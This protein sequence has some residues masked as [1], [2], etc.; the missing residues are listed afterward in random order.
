MKKRWAKR[1]TTRREFM[2]RSVRAAG[3]GVAVPYVITGD[4]LA[5]PGRPGAND[6]IQ[7]GHIGINWMGGD[8]HKMTVRDPMTPSV[9]LCDVDQNHLT[10]ARERVK[11]DCA[12]YGDYRKLLENKDVDAVIIAVPDHWHALIAIAACEAGKDVYCEKPLS[13]TVREGRAMVTGARRYGRMFQTGSQQR[14]ED[15]FRLACELVRS[16]RIGKVH[17]V[18]VNVW[19]TSEWCD[20]PEEPIPSHVDWNT[21]VGPARYRSFHSKIHPVNWRAYREFA[22]GTMTDW[23]A[24]HL[25]IAQWGLGTDKSGPVEVHP[26]CKDHKGLRYVYANG[27]NVLCGHVDANGVRFIGSDGKIEVNRG[28]FRTW[29]EEIGST[30]LSSGDVRL[31]KPVSDGAQAW[32]GNQLDFF[33]SVK[34]RERPLCDVEIGFRTVTMCH[35]GNLA[36]WLNRPLKWNPDTEQIIGDDEA[37]RWLYRP[38]RAPWTL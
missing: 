3:V 35:L 18:H 10:R 7:L 28:H 37:S 26:P 22:G 25:D 14:T 33:A 23:G 24:H 19:G 31:R 13:L 2:R 36:L 12:T 17:S 29:P 27:I 16:G 9:A 38:M 1:G 20:L 5:A 11:N 30:P 6:R 21:W 32:R 34:S 4:A 8:H 15:N